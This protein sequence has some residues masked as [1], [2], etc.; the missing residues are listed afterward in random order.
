[1]EKLE[2]L[3]RYGQTNRYGS[4]LGLHLDFVESGVVNYRT[5][6]LKEH[7]ATE[8]SAHGGFLASIFDQI[9]GTAALSKAI[10]DGKVVSTVELKMNFLKPAM[11]DDELLGEGRV[12]NNGKRLYTVEGKIYNQKKELLLTG[13]ATLNAYPFAKSDMN[14]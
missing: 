3:K 8:K 5:K 10:N 14:F 6:V 2:I 7:L 1:M 12:I 13:L 11:L 4:L 9:V